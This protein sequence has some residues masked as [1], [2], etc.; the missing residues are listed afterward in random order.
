MSSAQDARAAAL[1]A[2]ESRDWSTATVHTAP[3]RPSTVFSIRLPAADVDVLVAEAVRRGVDPGVLIKSLVLEGL[4]RARGVDEEVDR[5]Q[6]I[7]AQLHQAID[8]T[9]SK[10]A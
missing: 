3:T 5:L 4:A 7:A 10:V 1:A 9:M 2:A 6:R 8:D